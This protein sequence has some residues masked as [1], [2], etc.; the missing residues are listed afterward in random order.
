MI[1]DAQKKVIQ[2]L[3]FMS[4]TPVIDEEREE[5]CD[6]AI[7]LIESQA[8]EIEDLETGNAILVDMVHKADAE[9]ER[10]KE[11]LGRFQNIGMMFQAPAQPSGPLHNVCKHGYI[12]ACPVCD[13]TKEKS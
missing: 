3:D 12:K 6:L 9:I 8:A 1:V 2:R 7:E 11:E 5:V 10:L 13:A 4:T